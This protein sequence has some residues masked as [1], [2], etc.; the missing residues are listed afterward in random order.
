MI[1]I[2]RAHRDYIQDYTDVTGRR[3]MP[4][5][6]TLLDLE[7][8]ISVS[9]DEYHDVEG[10]AAQ[11]SV[12]EYGHARN[13]LKTNYDT[14]ADD[15]ALY[16]ELLRCE[17]DMCPLC[18]F[19]EVSTLDHYLPRTRFPQFSV[20]A[21]NLVPCCSRCNQLKGTK[22]GHIPAR[23]FLHPL[24][25]ALPA[26]QL[27]TCGL[28]FE[29]GTVFTTFGVHRDGAADVG[30]VDRLTFQFEQLQL[31]DRLRRKATSVLRSR[32]IAFDL[33]VGNGGY[34]ALHNQLEIEAEGARQQFGINYWE[35]A[36]YGALAAD[37]RFWNGG[38]RLIV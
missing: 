19:G 11:I 12:F 27:L 7:E 6:R 24:Y 10:N 8:P 14:L 29:D 28:D 38:F 3:R 16:G 22:V 5:R 30:L 1:S 20:Y 9:Y 33:S 35:S 36:L 34:E 26:L 4:G 32:R 18:G 17:P 25:H 23:Q 31:G 37:E 2:N 21:M 13:L 15:N